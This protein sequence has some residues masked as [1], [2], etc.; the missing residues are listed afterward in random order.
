MEDYGSSQEDKEYRKQILALGNNKEPFGEISEL[1]D[2][3]LQIEQTEIKQENQMDFQITAE[4]SLTT[5]LLKISL[6]GKSSVMSAGRVS[7]TAE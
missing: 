6:Q 3:G 4:H 7:Q 5:N 1:S 2:D